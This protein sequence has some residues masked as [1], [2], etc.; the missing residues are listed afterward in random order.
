MNN[1][2]SWWRSFG[3]CLIDGFL[4]SMEERAETLERILGRADTQVQV[5]TTALQAQEHETVSLQALVRH[6]TEGAQ[7]GGRGNAGSSGGGVDAHAGETRRVPWRRIEMGRLV[8]GDACVLPF[9]W[10]SACRQHTGCSSR[11]K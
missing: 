8:D 4:V 3:C 2:L 1:D 6:A 5:L 9:M 11:G 7:A 10:S